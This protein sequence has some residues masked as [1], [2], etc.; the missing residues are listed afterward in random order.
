MDQ[1]E[2]LRSMVQIRNSGLIKQQNLASRVITVTSGKGGVGKTNFTVSLAIYLQRQNKRVA[3]LDA[4]FGLANIELLFGVIPKYSLADVLLGGKMI[5]E[6]ITEG[7]SGIKF[8]SGGS[9]L[10]DLANISERQMAYLIDNFEY[11]DSISDIIL[12]DTGAGISKSVINFVKASNETVIVTTPEPTS[13]TDAY[14]LIKT[15]REEESDIPEFKIVVNKVDNI[16]EGIE[17]YDKLQKVSAKFLDIKLDYLGSIPYDN[18]LVKAVKQQR[19]AAVSFP[20]SPF[21]KS[22]EAMSAKILDIDFSPYNSNT[23]NI[24]SFVKRLTNI[25]G[26]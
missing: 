26:G 13:I 21:S 17:I 12:V 25:F 9:G 20:N 1:A 11:L 19:P 15:I 2:S 23:L 5:E 18:N 4:D 7:P 8:I 14:A 3:I 22:L 6:V 16:K 10:K 24:I